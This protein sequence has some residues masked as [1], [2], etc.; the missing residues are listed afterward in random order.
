[1]TLLLFLIVQG[2][3]IG[4]LYALFAVGLSLSMG[5][6]RFVNIAH[7][8]YI[9]AG[10]F[11]LLSVSAFLG[12]SPFIALILTLPF[13]FVAGYVIERFLLTKI[14][15][16][17]GGVLPVILVTLAMGVIIQNALLE[18]Y[19]PNTRKLFGGSIEVASIDIGGLF[20]VGLFPLAVFGTAVLVIAGLELFLRRTSMGARIRATADDP[21]A[22]NLIG[23]PSAQIHAMAMGIVGLT[24]MIA[25]CCMAV[26]T[27]FDPTIGPSRLLAAFEVVV[28]GGLGSLWGTLVGGI[29]IGI[30]QNIG[31]QFDAAWQTL[32]QHL[33]FLAILVIRPQGLFKQD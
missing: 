24:I 16:K 21:A 12:V 20:D 22:A 17:G 5:I 1:M 31:A 32:A 15:R 28:L 14:A 6:L 33:V 27:N 26:W 4:G 2:V 10:S 3:L 8:D 23:L 13:A 11:L 29:V 30:A 9:V 7:G 19:G 18:G 25:A